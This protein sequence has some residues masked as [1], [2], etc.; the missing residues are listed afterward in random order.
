MRTISF[1]AFHEA[2]PFTER[3]AVQGHLI[4][5]STMQAG[6]S[7]PAQVCPIIPFSTSHLRLLGSFCTD[8][9]RK[10]RERV[11]TVGES[12]V[13]VLRCNEFLS[14]TTAGCETYHCALGEGPRE[15]DANVQNEEGQI[16]DQATAGASAAR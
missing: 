4:R 15:G 9:V 16:A 5:Q 13:S 3:E 8:Q 7:L 6:E 1:L 14:H 12:A 10:L 2:S 11:S